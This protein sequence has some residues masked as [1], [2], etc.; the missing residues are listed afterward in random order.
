MTVKKIEKLTDAR[1]IEIAGTM[2]A[3]LLSKGELLRQANPWFE[4]IFERGK[5]EIHILIVA[6]GEIGFV[7]GEFGLTELIDKALRPTPMPWEKL[8]IVKAHRAAEAMGAD[9]TGFKFDKKPL[10][11]HPLDYYDQIW[12]FGKEREDSSPLSDS[13]LNELAIFMNRG[14]GVFATGDHEDLGAALCGNVPRVRSMRRWFLRDSPP[15]VKGPTRIDTLREGGDKGFETH[16]QSDRFP[17]EIRPIFKLIKGTKKSAPH[18]LL[19]DGGFAITVLP[20]HFHEGECLI[21]QSLKDK[22]PLSDGTEFYEYPLDQSGKERTIPEIVAISTSA[23]GSV[24]DEIGASPVN[25]R[26]FN[27]IVAY[28][29]HCAG[30]VDEGS[31]KDGVGR[32]VVDASFHHFVDINLR[33][34]KKDG[35]GGLYDDSNMPTKDYLAIQQYYRNIVVWLCPQEKR[36]SYYLNMLLAIRYL[37][38]LVEEIRKLVNPELEDLIFAGEATYR[39]LS[40]RFSPNDAT[41]C[42]LF[43]AATVSAELKNDLGMLFEPSTKS[44]STELDRLGMVFNL[45][46]IPKLVLGAAMLGIASALPESSPDVFKFLANDK[47]RQGQLETLIATG[48]KQAATLASPLLKQSN[49]MPK[50]FV[51]VIQSHLSNISSKK[52]GRK[53]SGR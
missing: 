41:Q 19:T 24:T 47:K 36:A 46:L 23:A 49:A 33:G 48:L 50:N 16:D 2:P 10:S 8:E 52:P 39:A 4:R 21:P 18:E 17:Q 27:I 11:P 14:G 20:D 37:Y 51:N 44:A 35:P 43:A 15:P 25:P 26:C 28:D 6:D 13:E 31:E 45:N 42:M 1:S 32:V 5:T 22:I 34:D 9:V 12:L 53:S 7:F 3:R 38:P 29:G 30:K 40:E